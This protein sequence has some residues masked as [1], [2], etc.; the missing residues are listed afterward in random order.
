ML[1]I[2]ARQQRFEESVLDFVK[3]T[4]LASFRDSQKRAKSKWLDVL[5]EQTAT[6]VNEHILT[7][8]KATKAGWE[9]IIKPLVQLGVMLVDVTATKSAGTVTAVCYNSRIDSLFPEM[10]YA[11]QQANNLGIAILS[12]L[13][14]NHDAVRS[15]VLDQIF[16]RIIAKAES[17]ANCMPPLFFMC[18]HRPLINSQLP[19]FCSRL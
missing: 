8:V 19:A 9:E 4:L 12:D 3:S 1:L 2:L 14:K 17:T 16:H 15:E 10:M 5:G 18:D 7:A 13:F 11:T 6:T